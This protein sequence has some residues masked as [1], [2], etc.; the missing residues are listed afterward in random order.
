MKLKPTQPYADCPD[1]IIDTHKCHKLRDYIK[2]Y[3]AKDKQL[4]GIRFCSS[5]ISKQAGPENR[6]FLISNGTTS[7]F[8]NLATCHSSWA[9]PRCTPKRMA[10]LG[11]RTAA[12]IDALSELCQLNAFM[13]TFTL[14]HT[15]TFTCK[16]SLEILQKT[17]RRFTRAGLRRQ[18]FDKT[19]GEN[20][21]FRGNDAYGKFREELNIKHT[22]MVYELTW[23][24]QNG[25][26]PHIHALFWTH[27][28]KFNQILEHEERLIN[29]WWDCAKQSARE[30]AKKEF[31][32]K[33][34]E[35][36]NAEIEQYYT[37][38]R[39]TPVT[40]HHPVFISRDNA[41]RVRIEKSSSYIS[42]WSLK[43]EVGGLKTAR[44]GHYTPFQILDAAITATDPKNYRKY[45]ELFI[46]YIKATRGQR[47]FAFSNASN[48]NKIVEAWYKIH[49][50]SLTLK[51]KDTVQAAGKW[52]VV[53][54]FNREF[55]ND[56]LSHPNYSKIIIW[57]LKN[58]HSPNAVQKIEAYLQSQG[59]NIND[60]PQDTPINSIQ[61]IENYIFENRIIDDTVAA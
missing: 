57:L 30:Y 37:E 40:G 61:L 4:K 18:K 7:R 32:D 48:T 2:Q 6:A 35:Q 41:G 36:I 1:E 15:Y 56:I 34:P 13:V 55:W 59:L 9:C 39:K 26:H 31:P 24:Y 46:E 8:Y 12:A 21:Q 33:T 49:P 29:R 42:G 20:G 51:K 28:S 54:S 17:W 50:K 52:Y 11:Q 5:R 27:K 16:K 23:G 25:W 45:F 10:E 14:P 44:E 3:H 43:N 19:R 60:N 58:G 38:W 53:Y 47:R 22:L